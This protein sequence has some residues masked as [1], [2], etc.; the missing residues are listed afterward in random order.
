MGLT[1]DVVVDCFAFEIRNGG[2]FKGAQRWQT[3]SNEI[4]V[5]SIALDLIKGEF[6]DDDEIVMRRE[7]RW[8]DDLLERD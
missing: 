3:A 4:I 2:N 8:N 5:S 7:E 1:E 6:D